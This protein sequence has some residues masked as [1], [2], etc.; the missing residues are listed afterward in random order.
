MC[1]LYSFRRSADEVRRFFNLKTVVPLVPRPVVAPAQPIVIVRRDASERGREITLVRW[2]LVP[3]W[4]K[5]IR[6]GKPLINARAET[7]SEKPSFRSAFRRRRC[8]IPAD[9]FYEWQGDIPGR[10]QPF[11]IHRP[12]GELFAFAGIWE[13]WMSSDGSELESAAIITTTPNSVLAPIHDRMPV[14]I[15]ECDFA[16]WL[17]GEGERSSAAEAL[18]RPAADD[19]FVAQTTTIERA[20]QRKRPNLTAKEQQLKLF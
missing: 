5:E 14:I 12:D 20:R 6:P 4:A 18:L 11:L 10:K 7:I 15:S 17:A 2:G 8:L 1:G 16:T 3:S 19:F 9:G 13:H